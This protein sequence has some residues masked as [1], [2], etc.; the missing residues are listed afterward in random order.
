MPNTERQY[1]LDMGRVIALVAVMLFHYFSAHTADCPYGDAYPYFKYGYIGARFFFI[2]TGYTIIES[3][4]RSSSF[5]SFW[6]KKLVRLWIPLAV[7]TL[8]TAGFILIMSSVYGDIPYSARNTWKN[9]IISLTFLE[10]GSI[11]ALFGTDFQYISGGYWFVSVEVEFLMLISLCFFAKREYFFPIWGVVSVACIGIDYFT[12]ALTY[13][14][15]LQYFL[16]GMLCYQLSR[17]A[18]KN[19]C[20]LLPG[21]V[22]PFVLHHLQP[23]ME[24]L[25]IGGILLLWLVYPFIK[26]PTNRVFVQVS[27]GCCGIYESYL[28]HEVTGVIL[29]YL[30]ASSF[31]QYSWV[32]PILLIP[33]F[34]VSGIAVHYCISLL[35]SRLSRFFR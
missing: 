34:Y 15:Y 33:L 11:N 14:Q 6:R 27:K 12:H 29:I 23:T 19:L 31:G 28:L 4:S 32:F 25:I 5:F 30:F 3:L 10:P 16:W 8:L 17:K 13:T 21:A 26:H 24:N 1:L 7:C 2:L 18:W 22:V 35:Q 20:W 9:L